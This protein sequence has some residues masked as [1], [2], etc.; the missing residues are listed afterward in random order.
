MSV[1]LNRLS[2]PVELQEAVEKI[3]LARFPGNPVTW[4]DERQGFIVMEIPSGNYGYS[5]DIDASGRKV[6]PTD[7]ND[8]AVI[9]ALEEKLQRFLRERQS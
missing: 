4:I 6:G 2:V 3:V 8:I 1:K 9:S 5:Y 7:S